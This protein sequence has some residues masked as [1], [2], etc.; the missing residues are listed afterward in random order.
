MKYMID[1]P[2]GLVER[3]YGSV[4][5]RADFTLRSFILM[6]I[7]NQL[8]MEGEAA[9]EV[10]GASAP[11]EDDTHGI[12][13]PEVAELVG[14]PGPLEPCGEVIG[15]DQRSDTVDADGTPWLWGQVNRVLPIK[16]CLRVLA[17]GDEGSGLALEEAQ[18][19]VAS[20][21]RT[22]GLYLQ[23]L[24]DSAERGRVD[25]LSVGF[26]TA[27]SEEDA[28]S[29][30]R[31]HYLGHRRKDGRVAG[32]S[33]T[34]GLVGACNGNRI[35]L[36]EAGASFARLENPVL[37]GDRNGH[38][39]LSEQEVDEYLRHCL[40]FARGE[41]K[42]F[43]TI[44]SGVIEG[45][46]STEHLNAMIGTAVGRDWTK[47]MVSTQRS[48][49]MG[50]MIELGLIERERDGRRVVFTATERGREFLRES[51]DAS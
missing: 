49:T 15:Q 40:A 47:T 9:R 11:V 46:Q 26:P 23:Q 12:V 2:S 41:R 24:D 31:S 30:F 25:R 42:A 22:Y 44:L 13:P 14:E 19:L 43:A 16:F 29:R 33:F 28:V 51:D 35:G 50:R 1:L 3:I 7:E 45:R 48:G 17:N 10:G 38:P 37:D 6:A 8:E 18:R 36:T 27:D 21:G 39:T 34:L 4:G 5:H 20:A 32:A